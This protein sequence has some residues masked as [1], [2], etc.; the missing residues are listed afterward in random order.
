MLDTIKSSMSRSTYPGCFSSRAMK[1]KEKA[2]Y[3]VAILQESS[4]VVEAGDL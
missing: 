2:R 4:Q 3:V 1:G